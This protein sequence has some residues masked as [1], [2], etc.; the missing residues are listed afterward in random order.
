[1][2]NSSSAFSFFA[3]Q[4]DSQTPHPRVGLIVGCDVPGTSMIDVIVH[5][6]VMRT[7]D[8]AAHRFDEVCIE[9]E[10]FF[11]RRLESDGTVLRY[12]F[13]YLRFRSL[14]VKFF[15]VVNS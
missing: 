9:S 15:I 3:H 11:L 6:I 13:D 2:G 5:L 8:R 7:V 4:S 14:G 1:M 10:N 12:S